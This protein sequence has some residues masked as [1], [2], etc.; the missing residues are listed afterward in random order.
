MG[1]H[2]VPHSLS[3]G[4][5]RE[6][7]TNRI[8]IIGVCDPNALHKV[9]AVLTPLQRGATMSRVDSTPNSRRSKHI[10]RN[11]MPNTRQSTPPQRTAGLV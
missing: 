4:S 5:S 3:W 2:P 11:S 6:H 8:Q 1:Y 9:I 10:H 7:R